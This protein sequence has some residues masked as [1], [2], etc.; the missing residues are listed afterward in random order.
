M[1]AKKPGELT[2]IERARR[3]QIVQ[4]AIDT[5]AEMGYARA[6]F[7]AIAR[8]AGLSST[9]IISYHFAGK[10]NLMAEVMDTILA[11]FTAFVAARTGHGTPA[12]RLNAFVTANC[13]FIQGHRNHLVT[14]LHLQTAAP[15]TETRDRQANSDR[16]K[17]AELF[18][19]GQRVG[20]FREFDP[21]LMAG[22]ILSLRNG[23]IVRA[24]SQPDFDLDACSAELLTTIQFA[25]SR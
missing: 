10:Q 8:A 17:L 22:F 11:E 4:A 13:E 18:A 25:T 9:G 15:D 14:M 23:V 12:A 24:A 3:A 19:D 1:Q 5:I 16:S 6:S 21:D 20:E 2:A 7:S